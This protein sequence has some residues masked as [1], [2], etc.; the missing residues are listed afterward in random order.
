MGKI[1][2]T[3][4]ATH[5]III[6][7]ISI[8]YMIPLALSNALAIKIGYYNGSKDYSSFYN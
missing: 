1:N 3:Y 6:Q 4:A 8:A 5:T 2:S 7:I